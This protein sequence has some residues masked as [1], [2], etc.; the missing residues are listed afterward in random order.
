MSYSLGNRRLFKCSARAQKKC[1]ETIDIIVQLANTARKEG[2]LALEESASNMGNPFLKKGIMLIVDGTDPCLVKGIMETELITKHIHEGVKGADLLSLAMM[3]EGMLSIQAGENPR[4]IEEKL[5]SFLHPSARGDNNKNKI[6]KEQAANLVATLAENRKLQ[7]TVE[8]LTKQIKTKD[9]QLEQQRQKLIQYQEYDD[10]GVELFR[11]NT[12]M[13]NKK[14]RNEEFTNL[15]SGFCEVVQQFVDDIDMVEID[16]IPNDV[17]GML[18]LCLPAK[19]AIKLIKHIPSDRLIGVFLE[20]GHTTAISLRDMYDLRDS[21]NEKFNGES[22]LQE[23][24]KDD[25]VKKLALIIN[26]VDRSTEKHIIESLEV[27]DIELA[28]DIRRNMF[29]FEDLLMLS[30]RD[31]QVLLKEIDQKE[32][33]I[34]LKGASPETKRHIFNQLSKRLEAMIQEDMDYMGPIRRSDMEYSQQRIVNVTRR[35]QESGEILI[36]KCFGDDIII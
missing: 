12:I 34:A 25:A 3:V 28:E 29:V 2:V 7:A 21:L 30:N 20:A 5:K 23:I 9:M 26:H 1:A 17:I 32:L 24:S 27:E 10:I 6:D 16:Q 13:E 31:L 14:K 33:A 4:I 8:K 11:I 15:I 22:E 36:P 19:I 35:L 18:L